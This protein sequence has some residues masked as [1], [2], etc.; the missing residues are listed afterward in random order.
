M[1]LVI[2][3][4]VTCSGN[5]SG[6]LFRDI[7]PGTLSVICWNGLSGNTFI[8]RAPFSGKPAPECGGTSCAIFMNFRDFKWTLRS[9]S[10]HFP[11]THCTSFL[12]QG[13][14]SEFLD[15]T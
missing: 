13:W 11:P 8:F 9:H 14:E 2:F 5:L 6:N 3:T 12:M 10:G 15:D 7:V 1:Y 4:Y